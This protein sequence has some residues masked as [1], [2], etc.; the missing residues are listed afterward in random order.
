MIRRPP[1]STLF[2]YTTLFRSQADAQRPRLEVGGKRRRRRAVDR[3]DGGIVEDR[4]RRGVGDGDSADDS[5]G[6]DNDLDVDRSAEPAP[7]RGERVAQR[8]LDALAEPPEIRAVLGAG[9][10]RAD[11]TAARDRKRETV[12]RIGGA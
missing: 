6:P 10:T 9:P 5:V 8:L 2:P 12:T 1:R 11:G 4:V 7:A 3:V